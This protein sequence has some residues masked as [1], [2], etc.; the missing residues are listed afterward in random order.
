MHGRDE[1]RALLLAV[2]GGPGRIRTS[3]GVNRRVYSPFPLAARA[4]TQR[5]LRYRFGFDAPK[6]L[7]G[8]RGVGVVISSVYFVSWVHLTLFLK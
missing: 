2:R 6:I 3:V 5:R 7:M 4:P 1:R 8:L